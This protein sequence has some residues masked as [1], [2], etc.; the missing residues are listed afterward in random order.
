VNEAN[1]WRTRPSEISKSG[2]LKDHHGDLARVVKAEAVGPNLENSHP[3]VYDLELVLGGKLHGVFRSDLQYTTATKEGMLDDSRSQ[4]KRK[5]NT[6]FDA[7]P[8]TEEGKKAKATRK[9]KAGTKKGQIGVAPTK[10]TASKKRHAGDKAKASLSKKSKPIAA[11]DTAVT[12]SVATTQAMDLFERHKREFERSLGRLEKADAYNFFG[13]AVPSEFEE[14]Y[15]RVR[16]DLSQDL[17]ENT[18]DAMTAQHSCEP[19]QSPSLDDSKPAKKSKKKKKEEEV[20]QFPTTPPFN[21][22]VIRKRMELGRYTLDRVRIENEERIDLMT[23]YWKSIGR[24]NT[25]RTPKK[26]LIP[27]LHPKAINWE[28]FR[29]DVHGMCDAAIE[30]NRD[31]EDDDGSPGTLSHTSTKIKE[32]MEQLYDKNGRRHCMEMVAA[33]HRHR[34]SMAME[35]AMNTEAAMQ[36]KWKKD[37]TPDCFCF[38][39]Q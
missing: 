21:F 9:K 4:R 11:D 5:Q 1:C 8:L 13:T 12:C 26:S 2:K 27:I 25:S 17:A 23:P 28:L 24:K 37:G 32:L 18:V 15:I 19:S 20:I 14:T 3:F 31:L 39:Y 38:T 33:N 36:G 34:F 7:D 35:K 22:V 30:R 16:S 6:L 10:A 29:Q